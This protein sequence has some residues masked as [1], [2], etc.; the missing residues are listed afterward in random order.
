MNTYV[1]MYALGQLHIIMAYYMRVNLAADLHLRRLPLRT[2]VWLS[3]STLLIPLLFVVLF[4][5][6][7][8]LLLPVVCVCICDGNIDSHLLFGDLKCFLFIDGPVAAFVLLLAFGCA[9]FYIARFSF[10]SCSKPRT[11]SI[12][13]AFFQPAL[14]L[15]L[16]RV[17]EVQRV[18]R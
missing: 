11:V 6:G 17:H 10:R 14:K 13:R 9:A 12:V 18:Q 3:S 15:A 8:F 16:R 4:V 1:R 7:C 2:N 5:Y